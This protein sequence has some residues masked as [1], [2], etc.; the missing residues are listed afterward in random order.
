MSRGAKRVGTWIEDAA[1]RLGRMSPTMIRS[2]RSGGTTAHHAS[3]GP[4]QGAVPRGSSVRPWPD[5]RNST[6]RPRTAAHSSPCEAG[7]TRQLGSLQ[8][9]TSLLVNARR[10]ARGGTS[11]SDATR[12][13]G[14]SVV[15][16]A[17]FM[18]AR[19]SLSTRLGPPS[20]RARDGTPRAWQP[21]DSFQAPRPRSHPSNSL[22]STGAAR[23][24]ARRAA[25]LVALRCA[26]GCSPPASPRIDPDEHDD[27]R[28]IPALR[29]RSLP[30]SFSLSLSLSRSSRRLARV[31]AA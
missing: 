24:A 22:I 1:V 30:L 6:V 8:A 13:G 27:Q 2:I 31:V 20:A 14:R 11:R 18:L 15:T 26:A 7:R 4:W 23:R 29:T 9:W 3:D 10:A 17:A 25:L 19:A 21:R 16:S 12:A 28:A 5:D